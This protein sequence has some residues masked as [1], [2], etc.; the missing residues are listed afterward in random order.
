[1][2]LGLKSRITMSSEDL[3]EELNIFRLFCFSMKLDNSQG[4]KFLSR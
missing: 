2:I 4:V 1:M 3:D